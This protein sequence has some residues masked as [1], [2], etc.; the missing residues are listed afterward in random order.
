MWDEKVHG[1]AETFWVKDIDGEVI[2][3]HE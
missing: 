3:Y 1:T 2:L